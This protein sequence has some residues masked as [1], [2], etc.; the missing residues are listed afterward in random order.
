[1]WNETWELS[2]LTTP[3]NGHTSAGMLGSVTSLVSVSIPGLQIVKV[4]PPEPMFNVHLI[5]EPSTHLGK[6]WTVPPPPCRIKH[7]FFK[8]QREKFVF[9]LSTRLS[10]LPNVSAKPSTGVQSVSKYT[11]SCS[12]KHLA[13][14]ALESCLLKEAILFWEHGGKTATWL[15]SLILTS[16]EWLRA[17]NRLLL[18]SGE[19]SV[20]PMSHFCWQKREWR[21]WL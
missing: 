20:F 3:T 2:L 13:L 16:V 18:W 4:T 11:L 10:Q 5:T 21:W 12:E 17:W 8:S 7:P 15:C 14:V 1:M 19:D 6:Y 9:P